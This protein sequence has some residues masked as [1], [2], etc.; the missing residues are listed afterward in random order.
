MSDLGRE[1]LAEAVKRIE[2]VD[3]MIWFAVP[4]F[5]TRTV[6]VELCAAVKALADA[7]EEFAKPVSFEFL[8]PPEEKG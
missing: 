1:R 3:Q 4:D 6:L 2:N 8:M 7:V 5:G